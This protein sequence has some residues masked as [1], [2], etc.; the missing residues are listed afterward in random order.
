MRLAFVCDFDGTV[1]PTDV[2]AALVRRFTT[3]RGRVAGLVERWRVGE[4]G[5]RDVIEGECATLRL[6]EA[7]SLEFVRGFDLD[8][9]FAPFARAAL[10]RGDRV[11]VV[12]E[13]YDFYIRELLGRA[14]LGHLAWAANRATFEGDRLV[15][16]F[17]HPGAS[18]P[19]C[20]GC[21]NCKARHVR[22][23][24]ARG[25]EVVLVGDGLSDRCAAAAA[26]AVLACG[27]LLDWC[28]AQGIAATPFENFTDLA[29]HAEHPLPPGG[30]PG[31]AGSAAAWAGRA[32]P[33]RPRRRA[34]GAGG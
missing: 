17:P 4:I 15:P 2:G 6:S 28:R 3:D 16:S 26:D 9:G 30:A 18:G 7:Q 24:H 32:T 29:R 19:A 14:G 33:D 21:G 22:S 5:T 12:S 25:C 27:E 8:P 20:M 11:M 10:E 1:S 34:A 13:G 23:F 31:G